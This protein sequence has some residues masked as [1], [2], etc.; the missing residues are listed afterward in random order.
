MIGSFR[1]PA[2]GTQSSDCDRVAHTLINYVPLHIA[3]LVG[4]GLTVFLLMIKPDASLY[5]L[6]A[7]GAFFTLTY[8]V[9]FKEKTLTL[10]LPVNWIGSA[11][12]AYFIFLHEDR[13]EPVGDYV[14][15]IFLV[16]I[17]YW[18]ISAVTWTVKFKSMNRTYDRYA[19]LY[20]AGF[21]LSVWSVTLQVFMLAWHFL[22]KPFLSTYMAGSVYGEILEDWMTGYLMTAPYKLIPVSLIII[23]FILMSIIRFHENPFKPM[24]KEQVLR[25]PNHPFLA[26]LF[27]IV[28]IPIWLIGNMILLIAHTMQML[29]LTILSFLETWLIRF[30]FIATSLVLGPF[31]FYLGHRALLASF[32]GSVIYLGGENLNLNQ[33]LPIFFTING[34]FLLGLFFYILAAAFSSVRFKGHRLWNIV[35]SFFQEFRDRGKNVALA[36]SIAYC[37]II[38]IAVAIPIVTPIHGSVFGAFSILYTLLLITVFLVFKSWNLIQ[39]RRAG[40]A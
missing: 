27:V 19:S 40:H 31:G 9:V 34:L 33:A 5:F 7:Q 32:Q 11:A 6:F 30:V 2:E 36:L 1:E 28:S 35:G 14:A 24:T 29:V 22:S 8:F 38:W 25:A 18:L 10:R 23:G 26:S 3:I 12:M 20:L 15:I 4:T 16:F 39:S 21:L 13:K 17:T 37:L